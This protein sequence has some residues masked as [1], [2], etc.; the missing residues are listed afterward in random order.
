MFK[1]EP[2]DD[3]SPIC[4]AQYAYKS[5]RGQEQNPTAPQWRIRP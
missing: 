5:W 2:L 4:G 3:V 1:D